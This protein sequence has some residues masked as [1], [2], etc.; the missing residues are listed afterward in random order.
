M[1]KTSTKRKAQK[2]LAQE[3]NLAE[4]KDPFQAVIER[5]ET[6]PLVELG[7]FIY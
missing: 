6:S 1:N 2:R 7:T 4:V 3:S 5:M